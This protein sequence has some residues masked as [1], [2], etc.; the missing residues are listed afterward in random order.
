MWSWRVTSGANRRMGRAGRAQGEG[1][2]KAFQ[3]PNHLSTFFLLEV[4]IKLLLRNLLIMGF[5]PISW[6]DPSG[7]FSPRGT[8]AQGTLRS[9]SNLPGHPRVRSRLL[10]P[11]EAKAVCPV[12]WKLTLKTWISVIVFTAVFPNPRKV[13]GTKFLYNK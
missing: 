8:A 12:P 11:S 13:T 5:L 4:K 7:S 9:H 6:H 1:V 2:K 3:K 10:S